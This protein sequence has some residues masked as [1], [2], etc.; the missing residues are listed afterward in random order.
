[1]PTDKEFAEMA[2]EAELEVKTLFDEFTAESAGRK[3]RRKR[4]PQAQPI[5]QMPAPQAPEPPPLGPEG[6]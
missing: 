4:E 5:E 3:R 6:Y 1:M 2:V